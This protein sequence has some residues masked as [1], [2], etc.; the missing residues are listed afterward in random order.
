MKVKDLVQKLN[1][2]DSELDVF[3]YSEA[4]DLLPAG[5]RFCLL[6]IEGISVI[7]G[8]KCRGDDGVPSLKLGKSQYSKKHA[9]I[10]VTSDF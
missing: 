6:E 8:E 2:M 3:C 9:V 10:N 4:E 5:H 7:E 1:K